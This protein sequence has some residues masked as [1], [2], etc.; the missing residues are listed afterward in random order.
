MKSYPTVLLVLAC[1]GLVPLLPQDWVGNWHDA[2]RVAEYW[3]FLISMPVACRALANRTWHVRTWSGTAL[4]GILVV[5]SS[6]HAAQPLM[7]LREVLTLGGLVAVALA[8]ASA[9]RVA[10]ARLIVAKGIV[11]TCAAYALLVLPLALAAGLS[12]TPLDNAR[13]FVGYDNPRFLNHAQAVFIPLLAGIAIWPILGRG[14][15]ILALAT[16][17]AQ[18]A[19][20]IFS[21]GRSNSVA[22]LVIAGLA[23]IGFGSLG[24]RWSGTLL[25]GGI[26]GGLLYFLIFHL[27]PGQTDGAVKDGL[28]AAAG[29]GS[30]HSRLYLWRIALDDIAKNPV[31]GIGPMHFAHHPNRSG[32][33]PHNFYLQLA[34]EFGLPFAVL[35]L[36][37]LG[38]GLVSRLRRLRAE[39]AQTEP[40]EFAAVMGCC[41]AAIDAAFSGNLVMPIAQLWIALTAGI[42]LARPMADQAPRPTTRRP[43]RFASILLLGLYATFA[44]DTTC[45]WVERRMAWEAPALS[46]TANPA[47]ASQ[48]LRPRFWLD[49]WF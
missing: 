4:G 19:L 37:S 49:G 6:T 34:A 29:L 1:L 5:L 11:L 32:A 7:A 48:Q 14:W 18:F 27:A 22:L 46:A 43:I 30:D 10:E 38:F 17:G 9:W 12:G 40:L 3:V 16:L 24:R 13:L 42:A 15:R 45:Q 31:L 23:A 47:S 39:L 35:V 21:M 26:A 36:G 8:T 44:L 25:G 2:A 41:A 28:N 33:H 20:L